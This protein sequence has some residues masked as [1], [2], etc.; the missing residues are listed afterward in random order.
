MYIQLTKSNRPTIILAR[1]LESK[2]KY[3]LDFVYT[4]YLILASNHKKRF[5]TFRLC[6][7][8]LRPIKP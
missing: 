3:F 1:C 8:L 6:L 2:S 5:L 7:G 4:E